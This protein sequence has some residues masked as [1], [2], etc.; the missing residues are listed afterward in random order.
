[1][2]VVTKTLR[3]SGGDY[4]LMSTWES[5]EQTNLITATDSH[6]LECYD[7][8]PS[9]LSD[10]VLISGWSANATYTLTIKAA[11]GSEAYWDGSGIQGF[12]LK[13]APAASSAL[14]RSFTNYLRVEDIGLESTNVEACVYYTG[15]LTTDNRFIRCVGVSSYTG[16]ANNRIFR[17]SVNNSGLKYWNCLA[18][19]KGPTDAASF[20]YGWYFS[21]STAGGCQMFNCT[22]ICTTASSRFVGFNASATAN[23]HTFKNC[24]VYSSSGK[25]FGGAGN[26]TQATAN[27]NA[28][29]DTTAPGT[30]AVDSITSAAF[31]DWA[32]GDLRPAQGGV[33]NGAGAD[34][35]ADFTDDITGATR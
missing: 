6:V 28:G 5:T 24:V 25:A 1:M 11:S 20:N 10:E 22:A 4:S 8:W 19:S 26:F 17:S 15:T 34:L 3:S 2:A 13:K 16:N 9:G 29:N 32:G 12:Y 7:D 33:L 23:G 21:N 30:S 18:V 35:S 31:K 27:N 14:I